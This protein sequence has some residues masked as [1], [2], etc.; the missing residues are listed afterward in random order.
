MPADPYDVPA[1]PGRAS[2]PLLSDDEASQPSAEPDFAV[3]HDVPD[4]SPEA[5]APPSVEPEMPL[6]DEGRA[7]SA[8]PPAKLPPDV[9]S[10]GPIKQAMFDAEKSQAESA[11][12]SGANSVEAQRPNLPGD[13]ES[14]PW[15]VLVTAI[16]LLCCSLGGNIYLGWIA[17]DA[18]HRYRGALAKWRGASA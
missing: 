13:A 16:A 14:R 17:W 18:R 8:E 3:D 6:A 10:A 9:G 1:D 4:A 12:A 5:A 2:G 11:A 7:P 15:L